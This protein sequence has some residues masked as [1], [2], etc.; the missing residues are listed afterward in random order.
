MVEV[1][2]DG[3]KVVQIA[4][5]VAAERSEGG[6]DSYGEGG[7][8]DGGN[9][10]VT[11]EFG[12]GDSDIDEDGI[13]DGDVAGKQEDGKELTKIF[14]PTGTPEESATSNTLMT[15]KTSIIQSESF[16]VGDGHDIVGF[17]GSYTSSGIVR[18]SL[19]YKDNACVQL[20]GIQADEQQGTMIQEMTE[21]KAKSAVD[22]LVQTATALSFLLIISLIVYGIAH[23]LALGR[24]AQLAEAKRRAAEESVRRAQIE[25]EEI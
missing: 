2:S 15:E 17:A 21:H 12:D 22:I 14:I 4:M 1:S 9:L 5:T 11:G 24:A 8:V 7:V 25:E 3:K 6:S 16:M 18:L 20:K 10:G 23:F 19:I 13:I